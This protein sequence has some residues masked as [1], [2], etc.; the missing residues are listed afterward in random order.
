[1]RR[2]HRRRSVHDPRRRLTPRGERENATWPCGEGA[3]RH[4]HLSDD[5]PFTYDD[6]DPF[7]QETEERMGVAG[8]HRS[9]NFS[10]AWQRTAVVMS[11]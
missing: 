6:L 8:E 9:A 5:W 11:S 7:S 1:M 3:W 2:G 4:D 10:V